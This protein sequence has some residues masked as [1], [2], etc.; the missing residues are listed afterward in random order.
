MFDMHSGYSSQ[1]ESCD[2]APREDRAFRELDEV[3][4]MVK[5]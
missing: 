5:I 1:W 4:N 3:M 2:A